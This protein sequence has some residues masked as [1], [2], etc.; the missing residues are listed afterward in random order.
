MAKI[1]VVIAVEP[2]V[3]KQ[4]DALAGPRNRGPKIQELM[5]EFI[6][7]HKAAKEEQQ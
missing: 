1:N 4:F 5:E 3:L 7:R 6:E 2:E